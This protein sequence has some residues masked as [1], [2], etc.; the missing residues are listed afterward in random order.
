MSEVV[1]TYCL[2][3]HVFRAGIRRNNSTA[4][5]AGKVKFSPLFF[6]FNMPFYMETFIRDSIVR[7]QCPPEVLAF[8][9]AN[10]SYSTSGH[11]SK[12]EGGRFCTGEH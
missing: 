4:I 10:E 9:E 5:Q 7:V 1:F 2:A 6:G 11:D 8:I 3:L 12:G